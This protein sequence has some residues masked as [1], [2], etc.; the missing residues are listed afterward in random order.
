MP[1]KCLNIQYN[2]FFLQ[3]EA[4]CSS[5]SSLLIDRKVYKMN[6]LSCRS[7]PYSTLNLTGQ[8]CDSNGK[9]FDVGFQ[10]KNRFV[11]SF[12]GCFDMVFI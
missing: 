9:I 6:Q 4:V 2:L 7:N 10:L 5:G 1:E 3:V 12:Q 11:T 8:T